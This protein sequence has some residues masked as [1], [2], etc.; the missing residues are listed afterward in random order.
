[1]IQSGRRKLRKETLDGIDFPLFVG[2]PLMWLPS[3][4][5]LARLLDFIS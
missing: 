5:N 3:L 2:G 4:S 1:M